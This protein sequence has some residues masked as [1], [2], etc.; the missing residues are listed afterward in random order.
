[1]DQAIHNKVVSCIRGIE[2]KFD[3]YSHFAPENRKHSADPGK[4]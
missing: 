2:D 3:A 4:Q 1:M